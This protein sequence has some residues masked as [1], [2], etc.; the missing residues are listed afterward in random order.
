MMIEKVFLLIDKQTADS[1]WAYLN[2]PYCVS[3]WIVPE[4]WRA[5]QVV[6]YLIVFHNTIKINGS[7]FY[8][9]GFNG[10]LA[11][12]DALMEINALYRYLIF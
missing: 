7:G 12:M 6:C 4:N 2:T 9:S 11:L 8:W 3:V 10:L 1:R 5:Q